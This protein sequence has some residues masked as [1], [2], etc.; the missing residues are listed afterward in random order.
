VVSVLGS[1]GCYDSR[2]SD[3]GFGYFLTS[4]LKQNNTDC[5]MPHTYNGIDLVGSCTVS[6]PPLKA[7][8]F[9]PANCCFSYLKWCNP[10]VGNQRGDTR[11]LSVRGK[12]ID[13]PVLLIANKQD[14][15]VAINISELTDKLLSTLF[16]E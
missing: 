4:S 10:R 1:F 8:F 3:Q 9:T 13:I 7:L 14:L 15:P 16:S 11:I 5:L 6:N 2:L 12:V